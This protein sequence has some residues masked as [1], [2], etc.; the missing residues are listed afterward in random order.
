ME[1]D[2]KLQKYVSA[3]GL[4]SRRAAEQAI[5][6][7]KFTVNGKVASLGD[8]VNPAKDEISYLGQP[9]Q[10]EKKRKTYLL[11]NKPS[12]VVTT[13]SDEHGRRTVADLARENGFDG[14]LYPV[15]RLDKDSEGLLLLTDDGDFAN[16]IAH[17]SG[18]LRKVYIVMLAGRIQDGQLDKLRAMRTLWDERAQRDERIRPVEVTLVE[19]SE[20]ASRVR[21]V[22]TEGKNR[23][24]RRMC[25][26]IGLSVIQLRRVQLGP[27]RLGTLE[28]GCCRILTKDE[29]K[30]LEKHLNGGIPR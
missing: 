10:R 21:F 16:R 5:R 15:G 22:L 13:R 17:P 9:L 24:I 27:L 2:E 3:C 14:Y 28:S 6:D 23:Q 7:G 19:R 12:G 25:A 29:K 18:S 11:L 1:M 8:R 30:A 4:M 20:H 26:S